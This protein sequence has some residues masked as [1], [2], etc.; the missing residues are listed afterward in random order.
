[1]YVDVALITAVHDD[2]LLVPKRALVYDNDQVFVYRLAPERKVERL[3]VMPV[4]SNREFVEPA[5]GLAVGDSVVIAGQAALKDGA[6]VE[7]Y[8]EP[9]PT[10]PAPD[11]SAE[12]AEVAGEAK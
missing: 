2:A 6:R 9:S 10:E 11:D 4:L 7:L 8:E 1:L 3:P 12:D 5:S